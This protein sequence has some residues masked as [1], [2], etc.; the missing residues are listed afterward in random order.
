MAGNHFASPRA[1][2]WFD[3][4][5]RIA[6]ADQP[7]ETYVACQVTDDF[8]YISARCGRGQSGDR[9]RLRPHRDA[10]TEIEAL[11][12]VREKGTLA[13]AIVDKILDTNARRLYWPALTR[14]GRDQVF[15]TCGMGSSFST[16]V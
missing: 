16:P 1:S 15:C 5:G 12:M 10:S 4:I 3:D 13:P 8:D 9:H 6:V 11:R 14:P 2:R 7:C